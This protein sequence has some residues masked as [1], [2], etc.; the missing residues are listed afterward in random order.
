MGLSHLTAP[1]RGQEHNMNA[2]ETGSTVVLAGEEGV[3]QSYAKGWYTVQLLDSDLDV[4][5]RANELT[6]LDDGDDEPVSLMA[7][8][9]SKYRDKYEPSISS[10]GRKS[11]NNGDPLARFLSGMTAQ[12]VMTL[13]DKALGLGD[14][15]CEAKYERLNEGAKRMNAGNRLRAAFKKYEATDGEDGTSLDAIKAALKS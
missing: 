11:L 10:G 3:V 14:G 1:P 15:F 4:K 12:Q 9:L 13:A 2:I 8:Q 7:G 6:E 5:C